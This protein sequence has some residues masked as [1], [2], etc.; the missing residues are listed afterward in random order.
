MKLL[1]IA[2]TILC[3]SSFALADYNPAVKT[4]LAVYWGQNSAAQ[5]T[6]QNRL[7]TYC[8][9]TNID[10]IILSFVVSINSGKG[11]PE[12][13]FANQQ[14]KCDESKQPLIC[15][16][17]EADIKT[18]QSKKKT[19]L[20][21]IGGAI[22]ADP[23]FPDAPAAV[24]AAEKIWQMFG[25]NQGK[26]G[27]A[28]PFGSASVDGFDL[29][30]EHSMPNGAA[31]ANALRAQMQGTASHDKPFYLTAAPQCPLDPIPLAQKEILENVHFDMVFVQFYNNPQCNTGSVPNFS[32][33]SDWAK[34]KNSTFFVGLPAGK[35]AA[36]S[37]YVEPANLGAYL[38]KAKESEKMG[39]VMLWDA[40]QAWG[41]DK[42]HNKVKTALNG[43][44]TKRSS[45]FGLA[46]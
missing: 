34:S 33:W 38:E 10:I 29:D 5:P 12:L 22:S 26:S 16:E 24:H 8:E 42:Y 6:S 7:S 2:H 13:N 1:S 19:I 28:R 18:C 25:P 45:R 37:G 31:F 4:N 40:S 11:E 9:D 20:L 27:I 14:G 3:M 23:G 41:N 32:A 44:K 39:G 46:I 35:T 36:S 17:I 21:S 30:F 43:A 15:P